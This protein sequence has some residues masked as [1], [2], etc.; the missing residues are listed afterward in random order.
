MFDNS[1][2]TVV[3]TIANSLLAVYCVN[4]DIPMVLISNG[5]AGVDESVFNADKTGFECASQSVVNGVIHLNAKYMMSPSANASGTSL[6]IKLPKS[7]SI[8]KDGVKVN[9]VVTNDY[10]YDYDFDDNTLTIPMNNATEA[11]VSVAVQMNA[12]YPI[13]HMRN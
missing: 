1:A 9:G 12:S 4:N 7:A 3:Y 10:T 11:D 5:Q 2:N 6:F 8:I 13:C